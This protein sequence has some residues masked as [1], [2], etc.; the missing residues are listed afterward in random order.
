MAY[1]IGSFETFADDLDWTQPQ[2]IAM[3]ST[4]YLLLATYGILLGLALR[5]TWVI[6]VKQKEYKN[7]PILM[8]YIFALIAIFLRLLLMVCWWMINPIF[9]FISLVQQF[10]KL[11]VGV[12]QNWITFELAIRIHHSKGYSDISE[13]A[14]KKLRFTRSLLFLIITISF[15]AF[16]ISMIILGLKGADYFSQLCLIQVILGYFFLVLVL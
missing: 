16:T 4:Y 3:I 9:W 10:A 7:L 15:V 5:N 6:I 14:K 1:I 8:F 13:A 12:V 11:N 2:V